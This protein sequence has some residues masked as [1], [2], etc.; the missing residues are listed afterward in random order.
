[1]H[2]SKFVYKFTSPLPLVI[3]ASIKPYMFVCDKNTSWV[4]V[5]I[6]YIFGTPH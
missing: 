2:A 6:E 5:V 1:M 3:F 4:I